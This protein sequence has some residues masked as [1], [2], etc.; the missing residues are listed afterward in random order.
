MRA[1]KITKQ[2][3]N[4]GADFAIP[5]CRDWR[6]HCCST[7]CKRAFAA[8]KLAA[9]V[10]SRS[11]SCLECGKAFVARQ[12]QIDAGGG[13]FC[14]KNCGIRYNHDI[15][16][17]PANKEKRTEAMRESHR[18]GLVA[19]KYGPDNPSW[20]GGK[21]ASK[22]RAR[23]KQV[24]RTR[25]YRKANPDKVREFELRRK[26]VKLG[27]LPRGTVAKLMALQKAKCTICRCSIKGKYH[28]DHIQPLARGGKH[29]PE[30]IQLLC[31]TCNV[32]KS[33]KDPI[34]YMQSRGFLL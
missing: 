17:S 7:V 12:T 3:K 5:P 29:A 34:E 22:A 19:Y 23:P 28:V 15:L 32:R 30:N 11:R 24:E 33:A 6:E 14:S 1:A 9:S 10:A 27:R 4:C 31:P 13:K 16:N 25:A 21:E 26:S 8:N 20:T 2:C 18:K